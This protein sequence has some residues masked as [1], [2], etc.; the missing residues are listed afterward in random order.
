MHKDVED[1]ESGGD[2]DAGERA[3]LDDHRTISLDV[4]AIVRR[5]LKRKR[6]R[7]CAL[8]GARYRIRETDKRLCTKATDYR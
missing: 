2:D 8:F 6:F 1:D 5:R 7:L 3:A 4:P